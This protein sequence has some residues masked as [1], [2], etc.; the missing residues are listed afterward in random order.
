LATSAV[1]VAS[2]KLGAGA[3]LY[4]ACWALEAWGAWRL[5][6]RWGAWGLTL[7]VLGL[8]PAGLFALGWQAR[9][10][11]VRRDARA[12]VRFLCDR[13]LLARLAAR[14]RALVREMDMLARLVPAE[15]P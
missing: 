5:S 10:A 2:A 11:R 6:G 4:P 9:L 15:T 12:Y 7:F 8:I 13:D 14:R 3:V 1:V